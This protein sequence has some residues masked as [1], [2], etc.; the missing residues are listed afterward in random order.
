MLSYRL[1]QVCVEKAA[2]MSLK[3]AQTIRN[4]LHNSVANSVEFSAVMIPCGDR[5]LVG[6]KNRTD[7]RM[8]S[9]VVEY[10]LGSDL[11]V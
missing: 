9:Y 7:V 4:D 10:E 6:L 8:S 11:R 3:T 5:W 1:A 2:D